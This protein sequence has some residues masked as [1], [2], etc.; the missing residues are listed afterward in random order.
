[1][2]EGND[3][4]TSLEAVPPASSSGSLPNLPN[5]LNSL[6]QVLNDDSRR[7]F[8]RVFRW[9]W[10][11]LN[12]KRV[13]VVGSFWAVDLL[14]VR[15]SFPV[16]HLIMLSYLYQVSN[17]GVNIV[18]SE[19][20]YNSSILPGF[21]TASKSAI[22]STLKNSGYLVRSCSDPSAPYL[23]RSYDRHPIFIKLSAKGVKF[24]EDMN[25]EV[26]NIMMRQSLADLTGKQ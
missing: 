13:N 24:I 5:N 19:H 18:R 20:I 14:R 16:S 6:Y 11:Y 8:M 2:N 1:M 25:R 26:N 17:K 4:L 15:S 3:N 12:G 23:S 9:L 7:L 10:T 22:I 21:N